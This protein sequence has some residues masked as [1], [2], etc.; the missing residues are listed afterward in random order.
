MLST[1]GIGFGPAY[2]EECAIATQT[3]SNPHPNPCENPPHPVYVLTYPHVIRV[4]VGLAHVIRVRV[5]LAHVIR[6]RVGL[7]HVIRVRVGLAYG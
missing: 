2:S 7:A 5:G 4:R 6:V 3:G 1:G